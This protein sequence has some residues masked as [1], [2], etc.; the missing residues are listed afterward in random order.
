M[1]FPNDQ[2]FYFDRFFA[3]LN[4]KNAGAKLFKRVFRLPASK[5]SA[6]QGEVN[7]RGINGGVNC[8]VDRSLSNGGELSRFSDS[9]IKAGLGISRKLF[10]RGFAFA[11]AQLNATSFTPIIEVISEKLN[12]KLGV[13]FYCDEIKF[14]FQF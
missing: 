6:I 7:L 10:C 4:K 14:H 9:P 3:A 5:M 12:A 1:A 8:D 13:S 11:E 2:V